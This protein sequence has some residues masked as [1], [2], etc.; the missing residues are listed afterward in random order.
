MMASDGQRIRPH[1]V[2][3]GNGRSGSNRVLDIYDLSPVTLA[4]NEPNEIVD[5][6]FGALRP[7]M[8]PSQAGDSFLKHWAQA[9]K[10]SELKQGNRDRVAARPKDFVRDGLRKSV[11]QSILR[12]NRLRN[13]IGLA[14][15]TIRGNEWRLPRWYLKG[16][17]PGDV[18]H[19]YKILQNPYWIKALLESDYPVRVVHNIRRPEKYLASWYRRYLATESEEGVNACNKEILSAV[20][21][22]DEY[23]RDRWG[24]LQCMDVIQT[25]MLIWLYT[26]ETIYVHGRDKPNYKVVFYQEV[27]DDCVRV[28]RA[29]Y[30][31]AGLQW[32]TEIGA[33][34]NLMENKLFTKKAPLDQKVAETIS[35]VVDSTSLRMPAGSIHSDNRSP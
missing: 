26:N 32:D 34:A 16:D 11:G 17:R 2:I 29:L 24:D 28:S 21:E 18:L 35:R 13:A 25:E 23:W 9:V 19:V 5:S 14:Y 10:V 7:G 33:A 20:A 15:P 3:A 31:F 1:L 8:F 6:T 4:R 27:E 22:Q 12:R 30:E